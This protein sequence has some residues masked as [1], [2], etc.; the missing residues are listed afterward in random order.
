MDILGKIGKTI[1]KFGKFIFAQ[2][3]NFLKITLD[4]LIKSITFTLKTIINIITAA[5]KFVLKT[6]K[7]AAALSLSTPVTQRILGYI[8]GI[9]YYKIIEPIKKYID[10]TVVG[11]I[12]EWLDG[13]ITFSKM[14]KKIITE[15]FNDFKKTFVYNVKFN[16]NSYE[17][18]NILCN[19]RRFEKTAGRIGAFADD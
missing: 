10:K 19:E 6:T 13:K 3:I 16:Y 17:Q 18:E 11:P 15:I 8:V 9:V 1:F 4:V 14:I 2:T 12:K 7:T 5:T